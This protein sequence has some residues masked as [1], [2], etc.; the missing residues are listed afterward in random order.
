M[1]GSFCSTLKSLCV[2]YSG[3]MSVNP[4]IAQCERQPLAPPPIPE[5]RTMT[6]YREITPKNASYVRL[7][8]RSPGDYRCRDHS[9]IGSGVSRKSGATTRRARL[10]PNPREGYYFS[11]ADPC[12]R[13][14]FHLMRKL[15]LKVSPNAV[16]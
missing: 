12:S 5:F 11:K 1:S 4:L 3:Q 7:A 2:P 13:W 9:C 16:D 6:G 8:G 10:E 14:R 15:T